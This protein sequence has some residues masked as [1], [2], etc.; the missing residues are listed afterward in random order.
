MLCLLTVHLLSDGL[1]ILFAEWS[2]DDGLY[3]HPARMMDTPNSITWQ[4][5]MPSAGA[6]SDMDP[7]DTW[8]KPGQ[9]EEGIAMLTRTLA[10]HV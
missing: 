2:F 1:H 10:S 4:E 9:V 8:Q 7:V 3:A 6:L 5:S